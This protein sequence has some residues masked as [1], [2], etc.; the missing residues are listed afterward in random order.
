MF[1]A[2]CE[3]LLV[4]LKRADGSPGLVIGTYRVLTPVSAQARRRPVQ[5]HAS[6]T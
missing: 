5:R 1:D 3:H 6:S 4:R 2:H